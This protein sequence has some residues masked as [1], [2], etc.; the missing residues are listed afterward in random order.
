[1]RKLVISNKRFSMSWINKDL[2]TFFLDLSF[3]FLAIIFTAFLDVR[4]LTLLSSILC[5]FLNLLYA[6]LKNKRFNR[7]TCFLVFIKVSFVGL[8]MLS[9]TWS[10]NF[11]NSFYY[12]LTTALRFI[13]FL[14]VFDYISD[15]KNFSK[16][17]KYLLIG[18]LILT[19]R[20]MLVVPFSAYGTERIG[21]YLS[22][23][24]DSSYGNTQLTYIYGI[25]SCI[26]L[27]DKNLVKRKYIK[28]LLVGIFS[29]FSFLSGSKKQ[30][31]FLIIMAIVF[32]FSISKNKRS[33]YKYLLFAFILCVI[34]VFLIFNIDMLYEVLG[35]RIESFL[36]AFIG[37]ESDLST[38]NRLKFLGDAFNTFLR[39]PLLGSGLDSF[40]YF[41]TTELVWAECNFL[42]ILADLGIV[43]FIVYYLPFIY[44]AYIIFIKKTLIIKENKYLLISLFLMIAFIDLTM[45][46]YRN[47]CLQ[48]FLGY[49]YGVYNMCLAQGKKRIQKTKFLQKTITNNEL[50]V[51]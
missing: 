3:F 16:F 33:L 22:Y 51:F 10:V 45:V 38:I 35:S 4:N 42:E 17:N 39:Y 25:V 50:E 47:N 12:S 26:V 30:L 24:S 8:A 21:N 43:G 2:L 29:I 18:C 15:K 9:S 46:S 41:N 34:L 20:L 27:F 37:G 6:F 31:F 19:I 13:V 28:F 1:M 48:F 32:V 5:F 49:F 40:K 44:M 7:F 23:N 14:D 11:D 36:N